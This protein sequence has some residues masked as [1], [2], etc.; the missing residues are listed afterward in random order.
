MG[1]CVRYT[2]LSSF[3]KHLESAAPDHLSPFYLVM[4]EDD[5]E[6]KKILEAI[7]YASKASAEKFCGREVKLATLAEAIESGS[8]FSK[9][10]AVVV[11][12]AGDSM[13]PLLA[14]AKGGY[15]FLGTSSKSGLASI[16]EKEGVVLD[17][18]GEK[19]WDKEKRL[20]EGMNK[21]VISAGKRLDPRAMELLFERLDKDGALLEHEIDKLVAYVGDRPQ[22]VPEDVKAVGAISRTQTLWQMAEELIW[23]RIAPRETQDA[24]LLYALISP[25]R[26]QLHLGLKIALLLQEGKIP[27]K[28]LFPGVWPK[29]LEKR[30]GQS[31]R[32]GVSYFQKGLD[33]LFQIERLSRTAPVQG[34]TLIDLF[35][36]K[37]V[38]SFAQR[39]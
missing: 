17:L 35:R 6:R 25:M 23:D 3:Q 37:L 39:P 38:A 18:L 21:R 15:L 36:I 9:R 29:V 2:N 28:E 8:L 14:R 24:N 16:V 12:E 22:I 7:V 11:D 4:M 5:Y 27:S 33:A 26:S 32:L 31:A 20:S 30:C 34:S 19:P 10:Q 1:G 13:K